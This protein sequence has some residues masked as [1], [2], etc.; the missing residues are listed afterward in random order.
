MSK[1]KLRTDD[2]FRIQEN[3]H[4]KTRRKLPEVGERTKITDRKSK[5]KLRTYDKFRIQEN[6]H[7]KTRR[8]L[9]E[10]GE[11]TKITE[12]MSKRKLRTDDKFRTRENIHKKTRRT[13]PQAAERIKKIECKSKQKLR[14]EKKFRNEENIHRKARRTLPG[15]GERVKIA[16][17]KSKQNSKKKEKKVQQN[18]TD[19]SNPKRKDLMKCITKFHEIISLGPVYTCVC[20]QTWFKHSVSLMSK[21]QVQ[22]VQTILDEKLAPHEG[23]PE[24]WI[25]R[26][27]K[28]SINKCKV[29]KL[30]VVNKC[31]FPESRPELNLHSLEERLIALRIPFMQIKELP[32]GGQFCL[33]GNVVNVPVKVNTTVSSL[34][35]NLDQTQ[36]VP[37]KLK[38][39][40]CYNKCEAVENVRPTKVIK[41]L[42]WLVQNSMLYKEIEIDKNQLLTITAENSDSSKKNATDS[43]DDEEQSEPNLDDD[44]FSEVDQNE[45]LGNMDTLMYEYEYENE[46]YT[47]APGEGQKPLGIFKDPNAEYLSF[48]TI[49]CGETRP[50]NN[51]RKVPVHYSDICKY[52]LRCKDRRVAKSVPNIFFKLK[53]LQLSQISGKVN[54]VMRKSQTK[55]AKIMVKDV[56]DQ[57]NLDHLVRLDEGY[58]IFRSIRNSPAYF[59]SRKKDVFAM[60][61]QLGLPTWFMSLSSADSKWIDLLQILGKLVDQK[62]YTKEDIQNMEW[63]EKTR[64]VQ[65]DPVTCSRYFDNRV[66]QFMNHVLKSNHHPLGKITDHF[67]RVEFQHRGSPHVHMLL[68]IDNAPRYGENDDTDIIDF[69]DN[70]V[71]CS[72]SVSQE[73]EEYLQYQRHK[74]SKTCQ[75]KAN[76]FVDLDIQSHQCVR[77]VFFCLWKWRRMKCMKRSSK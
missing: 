50:D 71:S 5:Q 62:M 9:P 11:R 36:T 3:I 54:L 18:L 52:E 40:L 57:E 25:C 44:G 21:H 32:R 6:I 35:R 7:R 41:A 68:W 15:I 66:H 72:S 60:I 45:Q 13:L 17:L 12:R 1:R 26:T 20:Y 67:I 2:K 34:P 70:H 22:I 46:E 37:V 8:K 28:T 31:G 64:L 75:K 74:H 23:K 76:Q 38:R 42:E 24:M 29:P 16:E 4:R 59:E 33:K 77:L 69:I 47:F 19:F 73:N 10:V 30:S 49:F 55:G 56:L 58:Y 61:R 65:S 51:E 53:K 14:T 63:G 39:K 48:P 43:S 27:C